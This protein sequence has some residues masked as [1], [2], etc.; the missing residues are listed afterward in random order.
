MGDPWFSGKDSLN[1]RYRRCFTVPANGR[2]THPTP[3]C[4][5]WLPP[6]HPSEVWGRGQ[7]TASNVVHCAALRKPGLAAAARLRPLGRYLRAEATTRAGASNRPPRASL[8]QFDVCTELKRCATCQPAVSPLAA[9]GPAPCG[10]HAH[11]TALRRPSLRAPLGRPPAG[12]N[13]RGGI[14]GD[15]LACW[16]PVVRSARNLQSWRFSGCGA[17]FGVQVFLAR[18]AGAGILRPV[19]DPPARS[20]ILWPARLY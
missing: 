8:R 5:C 6:T 1:L 13:H 2:R 20:G 19:W 16:D 9:N 7:T 4:R 18:V 15:D 3:K 12:A 17:T 14:A 11:S 10:A